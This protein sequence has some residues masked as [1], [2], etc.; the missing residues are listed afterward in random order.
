[1]NPQQA[2]ATIRTRLGGLGPTQKLLIG[3]LAVIAVM[4]L[5]LVSQYA[6]QPAMVELT[7]FAPEER[8]QVTSTLRAAGVRGELDDA[9][10]VMVPAGQRDVAL[11]ALSQGGELPGD[12]VTLFANLVERQDWRMSRE[13]NNQ[14]FVFALQN[15]LARVISNFSGVSSAS[16]IIHAPQQEGLGR[17]SR[18][19]TASVTVFSGAGGLRQETVDAVARLVA[20]ARARLKPENVAVIDGS[21]G[22]ARSV[23]DSAEASANQYRRVATE[24]EKALRAKLRDLLGFIPGAMVAVTAQ[25]DIRRVQRTETA[26]SQPGEGTASVPRSETTS[27][28]RADS[29]GSGAEPGVRANQEASIPT[30]GSSRSGVTDTNESIEFETRIGQTVTNE[31]DPRGRPMFLAASINVPEAYVAS[32]VERESSGGGAGGP[33]NAPQNGA[34]GGGAGGGGQ[35]GVGPGPDPEAVR[36]RFEALRADIER[37]VQPHVRAFDDTGRPVEG[38]VRV[39]LVPASLPS[40]GPG[41]ASAGVLGV[42]G[43]GSGGSGSLLETGLVAGLAVV[44]LGLML[45]MVKRGSKEIELPTAD[46]LVGMP[47]ALQTDPNMVG[48]ADEGASA[49]EGIEVDESRIASSKIM[50]QVTE[51]VR[52]EPEKSAR[53]LQRWVKIEH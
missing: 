20:G 27:E 39:A 53:L 45:L 22:R 23:S 46:E 15:E 25:P 8:A 37:I 1:M 34:Q 19:P 42:L 13:Q 18:E 21:T 29:G 41:G 14:Q 3:S 30:A 38:E 10:R 16:V 36:A 5:F 26:Y 48:E 31:I 40:G 32:L 28:Y 51:L 11:A 35:A 7:G 50:Q 33:A 2:L 43:G 6:A 52:A 17:S 4:S 24:Q 47:P 49:M 12:T 44:A 9:G